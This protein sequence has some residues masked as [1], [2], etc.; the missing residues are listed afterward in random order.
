MKD[1]DRKRFVPRDVS[2]GIS[3]GCSAREKSPEVRSL[4]ART[5]GQGQWKIYD[6]QTC[7]ALIKSLTGA[8][9]PFLIWKNMKSLTPP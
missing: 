6:P 5:T 9:W 1:A 2:P 3:R 8:S 4:R 7:E